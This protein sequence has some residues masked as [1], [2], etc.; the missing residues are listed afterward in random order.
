VLAVHEL[1]ARFVRIHAAQAL[2]S[3]LD[4][5]TAWRLL[6]DARGIPILAHMT[7]LRGALE[8]S[9]R[10]RW[11]IDATIDSTTRVARGYAA[12]RDDYVEH[13]KFEES[14]EGL[15]DGEERP[16]RVASTGKTAA[17]RLIDL[18]AWRSEAEIP[19]VRFQDTTALMKTYGLERWFRLASAAAHGKEWALGAATLEPSSDAAPPPGVGHETASANDAVVLGLTVVTI[20]AA[21]RA[22]RDLEAYTSPPPDRP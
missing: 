12:K 21:A 11:L 3:A 8:G 10:C 17:E 13:G 20:G 7:L 15:D 1:H 14:R 19:V 5:L 2:A 22:I 18:E 6:V 4:H 16:A 9:V